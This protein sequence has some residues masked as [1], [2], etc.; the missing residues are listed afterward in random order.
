MFIDIHTHSLINNEGTLAI[1]NLYPE[2]NK[3]LDQSQ[4]PFSMGLHPWYID[5]DFERNIKIIEKLAFNPKIMAIGEAGLDKAVD[6]DFELQKIVFV[7]QIKISEKH[8][9]PLIIH[10]V[11]AW[12]ELLSLRKKIR[13]AAPWIV[14][15]FNKNLSL[16]NQLVQHGFCLSF[17][18]ALCS[19]I[20][21]LSEAFI[22]TPLDGIFLETDDS[23]IKIND[24]YQ[25]AAKLKK[26]SIK[27]MKSQI[28][29]NYRQTFNSR[30][31]D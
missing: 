4:G 17:G 29:K 23:D 30:Y 20:P 13:P 14:H 12:S 8:A 24:I 21:A 7:R 1:V 28:E 5:N 9:K 27:E 18:K 26:V 3:L 2:N 16:A 22:N 25:T 6:I 10:C 31:G 11:R 15:G 19:G